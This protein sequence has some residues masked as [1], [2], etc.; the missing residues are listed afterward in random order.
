[1][2]QPIPEGPNE[3]PSR[4]AGNDAGDGSTPL[5][6]LVV[7]GVGLPALPSK[8]VTEILANDYIDFAELPPAKGRGRP[9]PQSL[10]G[11]IIV[12]QAADLLQTQKLMPD[13]AQGQHE[14]QMAQLGSVRP[15]G[16]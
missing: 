12:V 10:D 8:L 11:K 3:H 4:Q 1:M 6:P 7:T 13:L 5:T 16:G 2:G 14:V 15:L 9:V